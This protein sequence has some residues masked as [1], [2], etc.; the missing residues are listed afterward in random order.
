MAGQRVAAQV[1]SQQGVVIGVVQRVGVHDGRGEPEDG[2]DQ[3][4]FGADRDVVGPD[5]GAGRVYGDLALR[6]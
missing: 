3:R 1:V 2:V 4:V 6:P 5:D